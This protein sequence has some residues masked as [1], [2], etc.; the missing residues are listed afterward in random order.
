MKSRPCATGSI[1]F[2]LAALL[3]AGCASYYPTG[4]RGV[5]YEVP[6]YR[7]TRVAYVDPLLYP[8][9]SL[10]YFYYSRY[11]HPYSVLV[12]RW[13]PW[14][15]PYPGWYYGY[16]PG[17]RFAGHG[18]R[19]Y[20][21]WYRYTDRYAGYRPWH[22][23]I[24]LTSGYRYNNRYDNR[25]N[26]RQLR[27]RELDARLHE[28]ETRRSLAARGRRPERGLV[29]SASPWL[30]ATGRGAAYRRGDVRRPPRP[31]PGRRSAG[32][33]SPGQRQALI[34]RLR[35]ADR[36]A[37]TPQR[38][39]RERTRRPVSPPPAR[40]IR[41]RPRRTE[42]ATPV[43]QQP[44]EPAPPRNRPRRTPSREPARAPTRTRPPQRSE[45]S[46]RRKRR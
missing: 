5:Y 28:L 18:G 21:P 4:D 16:R 45:P 8:Y 13:D 9:W 26:N 23:G 31:D 39:E 1:I 32:D 15:Y 40:E 33:R 36:S 25:H 3:L 44:V 19:L 22:S 12:H 7:S 38:G 42:P 2:A 20:Y 35:A 46:N 10:D 34:E 6:E 27:V 41:L 43:R 17:P 29:P 37:R 30:P 14:Y 11:Y 24:Y